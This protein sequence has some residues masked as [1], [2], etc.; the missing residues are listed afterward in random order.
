MSS[1]EIVRFKQEQTGIGVGGSG[2][3]KEGRVK[4]VM[5]KGIGHLVPMEA[6]DDSAEHAARWL[7]QEL[8]RW[9]EEEAEWKKVVDSRGI[10]DTIVVNEEWIR[11]MG[12]PPKRTKENATTKL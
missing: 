5:L 4:D 10:R 12:G 1:E 6:V 2:G 11:R 7:G 9:R 8:Q 3:A